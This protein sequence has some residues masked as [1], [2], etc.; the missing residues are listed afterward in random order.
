V[1]STAVYAT[2]KH[3]AITLPTLAWAG[4][5]GAALTIGAVACVARRSPVSERGVADG[6]I[7]YRLR[8]HNIGDALP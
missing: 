8:C 5:F 2:T 7:G 3:W 1:A 6:V 4:G